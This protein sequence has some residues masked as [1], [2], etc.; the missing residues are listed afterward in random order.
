LLAAFASA[1]ESLWTY[2]SWGPFATEDELVEML[3][4][5]GELPDWQSYAVVVDDV[6]LGFCSYLRINAHAGSIEIGGIA[7]SPALQRTTAATEALAMMIANSFELSYRRCEWKCDSLNGPS[8]RA[9]ARLGFN[10][11]GTFAKATHYRGRNRDTAWFAITDDAWPS[12]RVAL[13]SWL[14]PGNFDDAGRQ[15]AS[16]ESVR[17]QRA[18]ESR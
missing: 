15:R 11:E 17:S 8:M 4:T 12:V 5:V 9:A 16:L 3:T 18:N 13:D 14:A 7:F 2:L 6:P 10:Y 1:P